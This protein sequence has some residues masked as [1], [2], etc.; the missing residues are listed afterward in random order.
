MR[1]TDIA[2]SKILIIRDEL[3]R[4]TMIECQDLVRSAGPDGGIELT[5]EDVQ[6]LLRAAG[7]LDSTAGID[8]KPPPYESHKEQGTTVKIRRSSGSAAI[9]RN[10]WV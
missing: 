1:Y 5:T 10:A 2:F 6:L 3:E 4:R 8:E 7:N 9:A